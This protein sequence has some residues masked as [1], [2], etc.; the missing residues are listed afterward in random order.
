MNADTTYVSPRPHQLFR[1]LGDSLTLAKTWE[2]QLPAPFPWLVKDRTNSI[3]NWILWGYGRSRKTLVLL[4]TP[5]TSADNERAFSSA[6]CTMDN[7]RYMID[8]ETFRRE[9]RVRRFL[10]ADNDTHS[11]EGRLGRIAIEVEQDLGWLRR[12]SESS[13]SR[14]A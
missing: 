10:V 9:H 2:Q 6:S 8:I 12:L 11:K 7:H 4:E 5:S 13:H 1:A 14:G 3:L